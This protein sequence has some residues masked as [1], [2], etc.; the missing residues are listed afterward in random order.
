MGS[1][2][3]NSAELANYLGALVVLIAAM[4][5]FN[6]PQILLPESSENNLNWLY[7]LKQSLRWN[8]GK[9]NLLLRPPRANTTA[10]R[11]RLHQF[12]YALL[13]LL[14][15]LLMLFEPSIRS[16]FQDVI[17]WFVQKGLPDI[18]KADPLIIA[19]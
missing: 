5:R 9:Q 18:T 7:Y 3:L 10:F 2:I 11:F 6:K 13:G 16:Q 19:A 1:L 14:I 8:L 4:C 17:G 12:A 15:Y